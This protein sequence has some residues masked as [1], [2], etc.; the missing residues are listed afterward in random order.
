MEIN[1]KKAKEDQVLSSG[2]VVNPIAARKGNTSCVSRAFSWLGKFIWYTV[3]LGVLVLIFW[4]LFSFW[5]FWKVLLVGV[6]AGGGVVLRLSRPKLVGSLNRFSTRLLAVS[7]AALI[8][9][10]LAGC[11]YKGAS[12]LTDPVVPT[13]HGMV[14]RAEWFSKDLPN[15]WGKQND[16]CHKYVLELTVLLFNTNASY[17]MAIVWG[18]AG[19]PDVKSTM[20]KLPVKLTLNDDIIGYYKEDMI[21]LYRD[22]IGYIFVKPSPAAKPRD[23]VC[24]KGDCVREWDYAFGVQKPGE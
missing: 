12:W 19:L 8:L 24:L 15:W 20:F 10:P 23:C 22:G 9:I 1:S 13:A 3:L 7:L 16:A 4:V 11:T 2:P 21:P 18:L 5:Q 17:G 14:S 6:F